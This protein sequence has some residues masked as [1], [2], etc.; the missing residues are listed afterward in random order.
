[1]GEVIECR[2][3]DWLD[4]LSLEALERQLYEAIAED[5]FFMETS[6]QEGALIAYNTG[7]QR[8]RAIAVKLL[9]EGETLED[10]R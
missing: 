4:C 8:T 3:R 5:E 10:C 1:M 9:L 6:E 2:R 7:E